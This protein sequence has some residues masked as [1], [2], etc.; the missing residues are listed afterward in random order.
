MLSFSTLQVV[1]EIPVTDLNSLYV[2]LLEFSLSEL[3]LH[4][5]ELLECI[6]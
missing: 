5:V 4:V 2:T 6:Y 3:T 1:T